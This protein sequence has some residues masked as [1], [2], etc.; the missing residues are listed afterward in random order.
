M[1]IVAFTA[2][3]IGLTLFNVG[4][5]KAVLETQ[6][7]LS[8]ADFV[9]MDGAQVVIGLDEQG[10]N[11]QNAGLRF[12]A[13][14]Q[15]NDYQQLKEGAQGVKFGML[16]VEYEDAKEVSVTTE[17]VFGNNASYTFNKADSN[18]NYVRR[19][20]AT[21][22][23]EQ[24]GESQTVEYY[25][26]TSTITDL[27]ADEI[28]KEFIAVPYLKAT[29]ENGA[30]VYDVKTYN[31]NNS[32]SIAYV[33]QLEVE[34]DGVDLGV[35]EA[36]S[37]A[38][39]DGVKDLL[40]VNYVV[41][42]DGEK[43][44]ELSTT[45][46]LDLG[47]TVTIEDIKSELEKQQLISA[48]VYSFVQGNITV[49]GEA[50]EDFTVYANGKAGAIVSLSYTV[51]D[52]D[53][54]A[55]KALK[56]YYVTE[57]YDSIVFGDDS[58]V[59]LN[60]DYVYGNYLEEGDYKLYADG[61]VKITLDS[62]VYFGQ[63]DKDARTASVTVGA[64]E[65]LYVGTYEMAEKFYEKLSGLY[66]DGTETLVLNV[67]GSLTYNL[68][69]TGSY[70]LAYNQ[71]LNKFEIH[72]TVLS[73]QTYSAE[74]EIDST[75]GEY[76]FAFETADFV[77]D[78]E[79]AIADAAAYQ[80]IANTYNGK[81]NLPASNTAE[82]TSSMDGFIKLNADGSLIYKGVEVYSENANF[83][84]DWYSA[85][86]TQD[87]KYGRYVLFTDG[88]LKIFLPH[89]AKRLSGTDFGVKDIIVDAVY[90]KENGTLTL[91]TSSYKGYRAEEVYTA[92]ET[93]GEN[94]SVGS[95]YAEIAGVYKNS[96]GLFGTND[97]LTLYEDKTFKLQNY[98]WYGTYEVQPITE[99]FGLINTVITDCNS[100][101]EQ[102]N[103][104]GNRPLAKIYYSNFGGGYKLRLSQDDTSKVNWNIA[105]GHFI[106][107]L[108]TSDS[109][110]TVDVFNALAGVGGTETVPVSKTYSSGNDALVLY[111][112]GVL[113]LNRY[114][115]ANVAINNQFM[116][117]KAKFNGQDA[118]YNFIATGA[119]EGKIFID[120]NANPQFY[121]D[122]VD[123]DRFV[124]GDYYVYNGQYVIS[125]EFGGQKYMLAEGGGEILIKN[126]LAGT[127]TGT[128]AQF[129]LYNDG[130][131]TYNGQTAT[132]LITPE[133]IA[134]GKITVSYGDMVV[135][136]K[137]SAENGTA[138]ITLDTEIYVKKMFTE[139]ELRAK[140]AGT[141]NASYSAIATNGQNCTNTMKLVLN[142]DGTFVGTGTS[143]L[144]ESNTNAHGN[145]ILRFNKHLGSVERKGVYTFE[146]IGGAINIVLKFNM[147]NEDVTFVYSGS[148]KVQYVNAY[149]GY[150]S[151][152]KY[153]SY[154]GGVDT[155]G[156]PSEYNGTSVYNVYN[157]AVGTVGENTL[158]V[159]FEAF[160]NTPIALTKQAD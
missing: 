94:T 139:S 64:D 101:V 87:I 116:G 154:W 112:D 151:A 22:L 89:T 5:A 138:K 35:K 150:Y 90:S 137:Y 128:G 129:I 34:K 99:N 37:S 31:E 50:V 80:A 133:T 25:Y 111:N 148:D 113:K 62:Q 132:Y 2:Y 72:A 14:M 123:K 73:G 135:L 71:E 82:S 146:I 74:I 86:I 4:S 28:T 85:G 120:M 68:A 1:A 126:S 17:S 125:F 41:G 131:A 153:G 56:G 93:I 134:T 156:L 24:V 149:S 26:L 7:I 46:E 53:A 9:A 83:G 32:R 60:A 54:S 114:D 45:V 159:M 144:A 119:T 117:G 65:H 75:S 15:P 44:T 36:I 108:K 106:D 136:G 91:D 81:F 140:Y 3:V 79:K 115:S 143:D 58:G 39:V 76:G 43:T 97:T 12:S 118:T 66:T 122:A 92:S 6:Q 105:N 49:S 33:S 160:S 100:N 59:S 42:Y 95:L 141:Y 147:D 63:Y 88:T 57:D 21:N 20:E 69:K 19:I 51:K 155:Y 78:N 127:Y 61:V 67:D 70:L 145:T 152:I 40:T 23:L 38:F 30:T 104:Y 96:D 55:Y 121:K 157:Y 48:D 16:L 109:F 110:S 107:W 102:T 52:A 103:Y 124:V 8:S 27:T 130:T 158:S 29:A 47:A 84:G 11:A 18:K 77:K 10:F 142:A 13:K 98:G